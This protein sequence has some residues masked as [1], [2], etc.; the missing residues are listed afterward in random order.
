MIEDDA[1]VGEDGMPVGSYPFAERNVFSILVGIPHCVAKMFCSTLNLNFINSSG[2]HV[3][4]NDRNVMK[5]VDA[6]I[7]ELLENIPVDNHVG[8]TCRPNFDQTVFRVGGQLN[9][10]VVMPT[11]GPNVRVENIGPFVFADERD[12]TQDSY[13]GPFCPQ[14]GKQVNESER[15]FWGAGLV[16]V[17]H[18][19]R[20][21]VSLLEKRVD[22]GASAG[23]QQRTRPD[24]HMM[25]QFVV[26]GGGLEKTDHG[27]EEP[28]VDLAAVDDTYGYVQAGAPS[29]PIAPPIMSGPGVM[30]APASAGLPPISWPIVICCD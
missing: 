23:G 6:L 7:V 24:T 28:C 27:V 25:I 19:E 9:N 12:A 13:V 26:G 8:A 1:G 21:A 20:I 16:A 29:G 2:K 3:P 4:I 22:E 14:F 15:Y 17:Q 10:F 11:F 18:E 30:G 5:R